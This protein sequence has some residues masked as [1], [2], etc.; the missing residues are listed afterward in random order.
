MTLLDR[1]F[2]S[3]A[4]ALE[5]ACIIEERRKD[6]YTNYPRAF[7]T[8][9]SFNNTLSKIRTLS[10]AVNSSRQQLEAFMSIQKKPP[11]QSP[12]TKDASGISGYSRINLQHGQDR[13]R[14]HPNQHFSSVAKKPSGWGGSWDPEDKPKRLTD[15]S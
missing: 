3:V 2:P 1:E 12:P 7:P 8:Y 4:R 14:S 15:E 13:L 10:I 5:S 11:G 9:I 6:V